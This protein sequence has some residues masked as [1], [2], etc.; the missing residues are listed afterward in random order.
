MIDFVYHDFHALSARRI[1]AGSCSHAVG[2]PFIGEVKSSAGRYVFNAAAIETLKANMCRTQ[3]SLRSSRDSKCLASTSSAVQLVALRPEATLAATA[4][5]AAAAVAVAVGPL[6]PS[7]NSGRRRSSG[8]APPP[9]SLTPRR[10]SIP[11]PIFAVAPPSSP[12]RRRRKSRIEL[13]QRDGLADTVA[14]LTVPCREKTGDQWQCSRRLLLFPPAVFF[15][16]WWRPQFTETMG[17]SFCKRLK[18]AVPVSS[19]VGPALAL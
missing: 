4:A 5:T 3:P 16:I 1:F 13:F 18:A 11:P 12:A 9:R 8:P 17:I 2:K 19:A 14:N 7:P 6:S 15:C 10:R